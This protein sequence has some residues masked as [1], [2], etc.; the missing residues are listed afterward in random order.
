ME[1]YFHVNEVKEL[2]EDLIIEDIPNVGTLEK[3]LITGK[4]T[5]VLLVKT[6]NFDKEYE[7]FSSNGLYAV[8]TGINDIETLKIAQ[9]LNSI[10][11]VMFVKDI[12]EKHLFALRGSCDIKKSKD[13]EDERQ[14]NKNG[15]SYY[16]TI[17]MDLS[18]EI[19]SSKITPV[20]EDEAHLAYADLKDI[21]TGQI[22]YNK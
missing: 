10:G 14:R 7:K 21:T 20:F 3:G 16:F 8:N 15:A 9:H 11:Y 12:T 17:D 22:G 13:I 18:K 4:R 1:S 5:G 6:V 2:K 19:D